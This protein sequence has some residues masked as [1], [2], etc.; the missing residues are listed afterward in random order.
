MRFAPIPFKC[1]LHASKDQ[2]VLKQLGMWRYSYLPEA[3]PISGAPS[4][5]ANC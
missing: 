3:M 2:V 4:A 5:D 1:A